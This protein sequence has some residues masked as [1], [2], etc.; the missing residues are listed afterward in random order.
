MSAQTILRLELD[1]EPREVAVPADFAAELA[2]EP[3]AQ[4]FFERL[5][6]SQRRWYVGG[7]EEAR[8]AATRERRIAKAVGMLCEGRT[9]RR[10][11]GSDCS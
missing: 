6:Y 2:R 3:E 11:S 4:R 10:D 7:I 9:S 1:T 8:T 5:S